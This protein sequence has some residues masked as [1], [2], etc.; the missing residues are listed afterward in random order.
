[1]KTKLEINILLIVLLLGLVFVNFKDVRSSYYQAFL[2]YDYNSN[3]YN[4]PHEQIRDNIDLNIP[5]LTHT[6]LP[7]KLLKARSLLNIDSLEQ[8]KKILYE[9]KKDN[10]YIKAPEEML[11]RIFLKQEKLDSA[12]LYAKEAFFQMQNVDMHRYTFFR[13]LQKMG[14]LNE[15]DSTFQ[16]IKGKNKIQDWY[17]YLYTKFKLNPEDE[18]LPSLIKDFRNEFSDQDLSTINEIERFIAIGAEAYSLASLLSSVGDEKFAEK[19]YQEAA[20]F[21]ERAI[22]FNNEVYL[23]YENA[24]ISYDLSDNY[25]KAL[26]YYDIVLNDFQTLDGKSDFHKGLLLIKNENFEEGCLNLQ[27]ASKK[28]YIAKTS[29]IS[30]IN[31]FNGLC[32]NSP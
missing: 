19:N 10:P 16:I 22:D 30:A 26:E 29:G 24:A 2:M 7:M 32:L 6:V 14:K 18:Y 27:A 15:L 20:E 31:V 3:E 17:D 8:A 25:E 11:A 28:R 13:V 21:Y 1:M 5:N 4:V 12:Y 9:A 23:Y